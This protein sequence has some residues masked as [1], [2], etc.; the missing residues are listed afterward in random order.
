MPDAIKE[1]RLLPALAIGRL[2]SADEPMHNYDAVLPVDPN[3][4]RQ[5]KPA[6]TLVI[7]PMTGSVAGA[8]TPAAVQFRDGAGRIK[9]VAPFLEVW[10]RFT[11]EGPFEP[12][13]IT[14]MAALGLTPSAIKWEV[15]VAN[16]KMF[17]RTGD[18]AD[19]IT[20]RLNATQ[21][22]T[23]ARQE[24]LGRADNFHTVRTISFGYAHAIFPTSEFPEIRFRFTPA[25]GL[26]YG[27]TEDRVIP[28]D[29]AVYNPV[30]GGWDNY[31][32]TDPAPTNPTP[33][34]RLN[35]IPAGIY[36]R[37]QGAQRV[38][39]GYL[40]DTCD[41]IVR[42]SLE[43]DGRMFGSFAR[44]LSGPPDFAPDSLPVRSVT[45]DLEQIFLGTDIGP[46]TA[47]EVIEIVRRATETMRLMNSETQ[48]RQFP[49]W[50]PTAQRSFGPQGAKYSST[51]ALHENL[52]RSIAVGL[53]AAPATGERR[54]A[55]ESLKLIVAI[56]REPEAAAN[57]S[58][59]APAGQR[60][61]MQRM[62]ALMRG[63]DG[64]LLTL[65]RRQQNILKAAIEQFRAAP[66]ADYT[67]HGAMV[68]LIQKLGAFAG[69]HAGVVVSSGTTLDTLFGDPERLLSYL[70]APIS[71]ARGG[72]ADSLGLKGKRLVVPQKP[73]ESALFMMITSVGHPM[74][75]RFIDYK[76]DFSGE[77]GVKI[78]R[79]WIESLT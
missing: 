32:D 55:V 46:V 74:Q 78:V 73:D 42:V 4:Y 14:T 64:N 17:R 31:N 47:D 44:I 37:T 72:V 53:V 23:Y 6:E 45:D 54:A 1:I 62:P 21:L 18:S 51:R 70:A 66:P 40:D 25:K 60:P 57:Y 24:L 68:R 59:T 36:A 43:V 29:R 50:I 9:P 27:H 35:T 30:A 79:D 41:G 77:N 7:D 39:L 26:V 75:T 3:G 11:D 15:E 34:A 61:G 63:G 49:F 71:V 33:R 12:L 8:V 16:L 5:L 58:T 65:T 2:G 52:L 56:L 48:N 22:A 28:A 69:L 10:A 20:A 67:P 38:N 13:T 19:R 76:D